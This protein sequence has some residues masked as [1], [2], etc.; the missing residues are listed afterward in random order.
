MTS[1]HETNEYTHSE[2]E[3]W[4]ELSDEPEPEK[5]HEYDSCQEGD[6]PLLTGVKKVEDNKSGWSKSKSKTIKMGTT[7]YQQT[8]LTAK[9]LLRTQLCRSVKQGLACKY[10]EKCKFAHSTSELQIPTCFFSCNCRFVRQTTQGFFVN[11]GGSKSKL[12]NFIHEG[13]SKDNFLRRTQNYIP[14]ETHHPIPTPP[15]RVEL[16]K[17][18]V[19]ALP[20]ASVW[21][22]PKVMESPKVVDTSSCLPVGETVLRVPAA[23]A[24]QAMEMAIKSGL[25]N[26]RVEII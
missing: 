4:E 2:R 7:P 18:S 14:R 19:W 17:A 20:K 15:V 12:C 13:E 22:L 26:V 11:V 25:K 3:S 9:S 16:P 10:G 6:F 1:N 23:I 5:K 21:A 8:T 24:V